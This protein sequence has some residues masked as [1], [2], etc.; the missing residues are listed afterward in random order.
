[1]FAS[2]VECNMAELE[3][4]VLVELDSQGR[5]LQEV[6]EFWL[7]SA[8]GDPTPQQTFDALNSNLMKNKTLGSAYK[9]HIPE[10]K[11]C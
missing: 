7:I 9:F 10:L 5:K 2:A 11:V 8:P 6:L 3:E 4:T 1:M